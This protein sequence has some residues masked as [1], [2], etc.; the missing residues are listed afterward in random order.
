MNPAELR[1]TVHVEPEAWVEE[2]L[3]GGW[4]AA[5]RILPDPDGSPT[6]AE[7]RVFPDH[8]RR[9]AGRWAPEHPMVNAREH[10]PRGGLTSR[11]LRE[12]KVPGAVLFTQRLMDEY[13]KGWAALGA[14]AVSELFEP[15]G[16]TDEGPKRGRPPLSD[17][18]LARAARI[19][20]RAV[21]DGQPIDRVREELG[22]SEDTAR[23]RVGMARKRGLLTE[24]PPGRPGGRLT[25]KAKALLDRKGKRK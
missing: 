4:I 24:A 3:P 2:P 8:A 22:V 15:H 12:I 9:S 25:P 16:L 1:R 11:L 14:D 20:E 23:K 13:A 10:V 19:Y 5:F 6:V 7:L 18:E 21:K 17:L